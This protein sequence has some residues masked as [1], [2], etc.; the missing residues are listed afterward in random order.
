LYADK[1]GNIDVQETCFDHGAGL[2]QH[3]NWRMPSGARTSQAN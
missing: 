1:L 3:F 2:E